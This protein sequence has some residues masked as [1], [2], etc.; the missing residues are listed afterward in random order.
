MKILLLTEAAATGVGRHVC[1]LGEG[2]AARGHAVYL[3]YSPLR[4]DAAFVARLETR[5][6]SAEPVRIPRGS[7]FGDLAA[8]SSV[9]RYIRARGPFDVVHCHS[10]K[11]GLTGRLAA[12]GA[13]A[14]VLYTPHAFSTMNPNWPAPVR[15]ALR[16]CEKTL[17]RLTDSI[18][19]VSAEE[20][21]HALSLG[22]EPKRVVSIPNGITYTLSNAGERERLRRTWGIPG[23]GVCIGAVGR[24]TR[25]KNF[26]LLLRAAADVLRTRHGSV[27]AV[28]GDGPL[29][30]D[31][32]RLAAEL[33]IEASLRWL[34]AIDGA[35]AMA[36]FDI[37]ALTSL[38]E[39]FPYVLLE[40]MSAGLPIV[41]TNVGGVGSLIAHEATGFI[42]PPDSGV[43]TGHLARLVD[44]MSLRRRMGASASA[45][46][47]SFSLNQM[48][49][50]T[51]AEYRRTLPA[52]ARRAS[53]LDVPVS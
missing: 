13:G 16:L 32:Q 19:T 44:D 1:D 36:A 25:Q 12:I 31:L 39:G 52:A 45:R 8:I 2:L 26:E 17:A 14:A 37:F 34:G 47:A 46:V 27:L 15:A 29:R 33:G 50:A 49:E 7:G 43:I 6:Y 38:Y 10:S 3:L 51:V 53:A 20:R 9:R 30:G 4:M 35:Q 23:N 18:I 11:A 48:V 28:V 22:I 42:A 41:S 21:D 40:A 5:H 24:L